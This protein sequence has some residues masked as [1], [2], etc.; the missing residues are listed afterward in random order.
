M[1][2]LIVYFLLLSL[3]YS[4]N[5]L[6]DY[7]Q[8]EFMSEYASNKVI[9]PED[10]TSIEWEKPHK[11]LGKVKQGPAIDIEF[12]FRNTG[13]KPFVFDSV[14][15]TCGCTKFSIPKEPVK[16][17][18]K[19]IMVVKFTTNDQPLAMMERHVYVKANTYGSQY[20]TL[21]FKLELVD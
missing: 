9:S 13:D 15:L 11:D 19:G 1:R 6:A 20:H 18:K 17:G 5:N 2:N 21:S 14:I 10:F 16:P 4:C 8:T 12:S 7:N 3:M